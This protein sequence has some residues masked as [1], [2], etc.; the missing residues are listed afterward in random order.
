MPESS[1]SVAIKPGSRFAHLM[2][3]M[4]FWHEVIQVPH[5]EQALSEGIGS[6]HDL[7][8][9]GSQYCCVDDDWTAAVVNFE[10]SYFSSLPIH[11]WMDFFDEPIQKIVT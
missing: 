6:G 5:D 9:V 4:A 8:V 2:K 1:S 3:G 10:P 7:T 11:E